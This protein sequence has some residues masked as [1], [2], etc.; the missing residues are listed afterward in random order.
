MIFTIE[1]AQYFGEMIEE[2]PFW[3]EQE[4]S[5]PDNLIDFF[6]GHFNT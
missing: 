4:E 1:E 5:F 2:F 3:S 6:S